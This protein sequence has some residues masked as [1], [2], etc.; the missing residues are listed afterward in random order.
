[1]D[2]TILDSVGPEAS[3]LVIGKAQKI[4]VAD[5]GVDPADARFRSSLPRD[6]EQRRADALPTGARRDMRS[7]AP[8]PSGVP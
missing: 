1:M 8:Q 7:D 2:H 6:R 5:R 3:R 4:V